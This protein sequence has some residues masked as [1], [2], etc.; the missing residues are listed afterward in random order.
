MLGRD[1]RP[2]GGAVLLLGP[3]RLG[4]DWSTSGRPTSGTGRSS[5]A[6]SR[7]GEFSVFYLEGRRVRRLHVGG[8]LGGPGARPAADRRRH[9]R[10]PGRALDTHSTVILRDHAAGSSNGKTPASGAGYRGSSPCPAASIVRAA[11]AGPRVSAAA[12]T[13]S[14]VQAAVGA[15][16]SPAAPRACRCSTIWPC[17][18]TAIRPARRIVDSRCAMTI[19]VRPASR[20]R[21][22]SSMRRLGVDVDV[23]GRL[24]EDED[25]RIGDQR[26]GEGDQLALPGG[27]LRRRARRPR[28][29]SPPAAPR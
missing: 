10:R 8:P 20:R 9:G 27:E 6:R 21:R 12:A 25:P 11:S 16:A 3:G 19:A 5:A 24:V 7:T 18:S 14:P 17:S 13:P 29:R 1:V 4:L 26:A 22:P 28:C 15:P 23:R 2:R